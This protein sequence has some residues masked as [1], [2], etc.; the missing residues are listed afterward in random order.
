MSF[1][2]PSSSS[3]IPPTCFNQYKVFQPKANQNASL[4]PCSTFSYGKHSFCMTEN[5]HT[6]LR[7]KP[8]SALRSTT[9]DCMKPNYQSNGDDIISFNFGDEEKEDIEDTGSPWEGAVIYKRN[10][11]ITHVE[12]CTTLERLGLGKLSTEVSK[13]RASVM[14]LRVTKAVKDF[15]LGTPVHVSIDITRKKQKLRLDGIIKTVFTLRCSR[16]GEPAAESIFSNFSL[17]LTEEPVEEPEI[18]NMGMIYGEN[19]ANFITGSGEDCEE[20]DDDASIDFEDRLYF[21]PKEKEID[22]SKHIRDLLHLEIIISSICDPNCKGMCF[23][24]GVNLNTSTCICSKEEMKTNSFGALGN[25]MQQM[26]PNK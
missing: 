7:E 26:Q 6:I 11:S 22:I 4:S 13:S 8:L 25:L 2:I 15:L 24:C 21:P 18:I 14:G 20:E 9:I 16:C 1:V 10:S 23:N 3:M 17:L 5:V 19:K 12:Y